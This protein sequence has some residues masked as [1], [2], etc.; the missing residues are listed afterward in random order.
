VALVFCQSR[1]AVAEFAQWLG[2]HGFRTVS[3]SGALSRA[4][5]EEAISSLRSGSA[6]ICVATDLAARGLDLPKVDLVI[7]AGMPQSPEALLHRCGR[8]GRA[9]RNGLAVL[10]VSAANR[11]RAERYAFRAGLDLNWTDAP[12]RAELVARDDERMLSDSVR[13]GVEPAEHAGIVARLVAAHSPESLARAYAGLW[14]SLRP[15]L[16]I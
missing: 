4:E 5:R 1:A 3:L 15:V 8:T 6:P 14:R 11:R 13:F 12:G 10:V 7:H 16:P 2:E 9:G